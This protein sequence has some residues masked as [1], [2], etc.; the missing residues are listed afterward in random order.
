[1]ASGTPEAGDFLSRGTLFRR[2]PNRPG[3]W[4]PDG[5]GPHGKPT[6]NA[7]RT[8]DWRGETGISTQFAEISPIELLTPPADALKDF[9]DFGLCSIDIDVF[10]AEIKRLRDTGFLDVDVAVRRSPNP[11]NPTHCDIS[12]V[13]ATVRKVLARVAVGLKRPGI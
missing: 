2:V 6:E 8:R 4:D 13:N 9:P 5:G 10:L 7:F 1:M 12:P 3:F 11:H